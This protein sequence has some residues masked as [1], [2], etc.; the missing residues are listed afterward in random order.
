MELKISSPCPVSWDSLAGDARVRYC[1]QCR[2]NVYNLADMSPDEVEQLVRKTEGRLC[3]R[4]Y[5]REDQTATLRDCGQSR[6][7]RR[8]RA[9]LAVA[10]PLLLGAAAWLCWTPAGAGPAAEPTWMQMVLDWIH[11]KPPPTPQPPA[12]RILLGE[13][14]CPAPKP[15]P[16]PVTRQD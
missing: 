12:P 4:L 8:I 6:L 11:P 16:A 15:P 9:T 5:V 2:L 3:G 13:V 14:A 1:G 10:V 7:R